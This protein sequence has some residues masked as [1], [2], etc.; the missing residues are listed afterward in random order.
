MQ[1]IYIAIGNQE[2][3]KIKVSSKTVKHFH[4]DAIITIITDLPEY[5]S[6]IADVC[7]LYNHK[8]GLTDI[9]SSRDIKTSLFEYTNNDFVFLDS[10]TV[11]LGSL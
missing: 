5:Y 1:F 6:D 3:E 7:I 11:L 4:T 9:Q 2:F 10:D 8:E